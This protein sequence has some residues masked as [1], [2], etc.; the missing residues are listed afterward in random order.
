MANKR[1]YNIVLQ[2]YPS[3]LALR[4]NSEQKLPTEPVPEVPK[5]KPITMSMKLKLNKKQK[6]KEFEAKI[7]QVRE[8]LLAPVPEDKP[9]VIVSNRQDWLTR[10]FTDHHY[11]RDIRV[12]RNS[13]MHRGA[14]MNIAK[15]KL[16]A[17]SCPDIYRNSMWS[18]EDQE[19]KVGVCLC[20]F[21][22][23]KLTSYF[24]KG[25]LQF[26]KMC[27]CLGF[28]TWGRRLLS[29]INKTF[30]FNM[31]TEFHF[32]MMNLS[33]LVLFIWFIVPYF[34]I[35]DFMSDNNYTEAQGSAMLSIFGVATIIGIVSANTKI[36][37]Y[38]EFY[39]TFWTKLYVHIFL[40]RIIIFSS[41]NS[42]ANIAV[43]TN[44]RFVFFRWALDGW[45]ICL[46]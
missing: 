16:R 10:Q 20:I 39:Q 42:I 11:L 12:H 37:C 21:T 15:Y 44:I 7:D 9:A 43:Y 23:F 14:M 17:S 34:Y 22:Y 33:T 2:N 4:S 30:D 6:K 41:Y 36:F 46:G 31:F 38:Y 45:V 27:C 13:I 26:L 25:A 8:K 28:Q 1:I 5:G 29:M 3:L 35:S 24:V 18:M 40:K 32:L 19:E